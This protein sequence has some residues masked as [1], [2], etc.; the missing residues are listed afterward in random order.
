MA[1]T[2][3]LLLT[4][5]N[6]RPT[7]FTPERI[8]QIKNLV[9]RGKSRHEIAE[10]LD[11]PVGSLQVTCSRLGISLRRAFL[12]NGVTVRRRGGQRRDGIGPN[13]RFK[14]STVSPPP[15]GQHHHDS[16]SGQKIEAPREREPAKVISLMDALRRSVATES[17]RESEK[18]AGRR[19]AR[20]RAP[21]RAA[22]S[23]A[24][25]RAS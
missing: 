16:Q 15:A 20:H 8:Q 23:T 24:R 10:L 14:V 6:G 17:G 7:T 3:T 11:V 25:K 19:A 4:R 13:H 18:P 1:Q 12:D 2:T 21:K 9:E 22:R 5:N